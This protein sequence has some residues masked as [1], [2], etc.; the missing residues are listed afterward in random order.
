MKY[1]IV[2][3]IGDKIYYKIQIKKL[4]WWFDLTYGHYANFFGESCGAFSSIK[5]AQE[6][7]LDNHGPSAKQVNFELA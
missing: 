7:M 4:W 5:L 2:P 3:C 6:D 1:R